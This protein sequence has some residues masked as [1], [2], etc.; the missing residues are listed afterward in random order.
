M[1][2]DAA[3]AV[4]AL[5]QLRAQAS[6]E[7]AETPA[8]PVDPHASAVVTIDGSPTCFVVSDDGEELTHFH[9]TILDQA[10]RTSRSHGSHVCKLIERL[11]RSQGVDPRHAGPIKVV[12]IQEAY[13][14]RIRLI[15]RAIL[16]YRR[17]DN[18]TVH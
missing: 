16:Q 6:K 8:R 1:S 15:D 14:D 3:L 11:Y 18:A 7:L 10:T 9:A 17:P 12:S 13:R 4:T 5:A 2:D